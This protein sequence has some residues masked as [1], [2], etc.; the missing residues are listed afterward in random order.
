MAERIFEFGQFVIHPKD[1]K[2]ICKIFVSEPE[3]EKSFGRLIGIIEIE[4][5][6]SK[7][8]FQILEKLSTEIQ[9]LYFKTAEASIKS[10]PNSSSNFET[11]FEHALYKINQIIFEV[12]NQLFL[13]QMSFEP[14]IKLPGKINAALALIQNN[15]LYLSQSGHIFSFLIYQTKPNDYK[16]INILENAA[17]QEAKQTNKQVSFFS[18]IINGQIEIGNFFVFCTKS[19]LDYLSIDK[20]KKTIAS[21]SPDESSL[22]IKNLL[23]EIESSSSF[24]TLI[25][26]PQPEIRESIS[27]Q[28]VQTQSSDKISSLKSMHELL[29][30]ESKTEKLLTPSLKLNIK[31]PFLNILAGLRPKEGKNFKNVT[32]KILKLLIYYPCLLIGKTLYSFFR[33]I[34]KSIL[35]IFY[36]ILR[37]KEKRKKIAQEILQGLKQPFKKTAVWFAALPKLSKI[38]LLIA[39]IFIFLFAQSIFFL[40]K[41]YENEAEIEAYNVTVNTIQ[42]KKNEAEA[43]LIYND[44]ENARKKL[45]EAKDLAEELPQNS[46][47]R[48]ETREN[49]LNEIQVLLAKLQHIVDID[50]PFFITDLLNQDSQAATQNLFALGDNLYTFNPQNNLIYKINAENKAVEIIDSTIPAPNHLEI[51]VQKNKDSI[52]FYHTGKSLFEFGLE[53]KTG[54]TIDIILENS[55]QELKDIDLYNQRLYLLDVKNNQIW[56][57][58]PTL[59]GYA[60][61]APWL[62]ENLDIT[63]ASSIAIDGEIYLAKNNG[64]L[65]RL[66]NGYKENFEVKID[67]ILSSPAKIWT[68]PETKYLY[69]LEPATKRLIV[70]DKN[71][72]LKIQYRSNQFDNLKDFVVLEKEKKIYLLCGTKIYGIAATHL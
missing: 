18:N 49:L 70:L 20:L 57:H 72:K 38:F 54:K 25:I 9:N 2:S 60:R 24:A 14:K 64:E 51:G 65:W 66:A 23:D 32:F 50:N 58:L 37:Q 26:R 10:Q 71:G 7:A 47:K 28:T 41:K 3:K 36:F 59:S 6:K 44:E 13:S 42:N 56:K 4:S 15:N 5:P 45:L 48:K 35:L 67:P 46:K 30:T 55:E 31:K 62:K 68:S 63:S 69:I 1:S 11:I 61:G 17:G 52:L 29:A 22:L 39:L 53:N 34:Y 21:H 27:P 33:L 19:I 43:S 12:S 16:I 40:N 8:N